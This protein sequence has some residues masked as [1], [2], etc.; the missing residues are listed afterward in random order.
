MADL[1]SAILRGTREAA[2]LHRDLGMR[3]HIAEHGGRIDVFGT[4]VTYGVP[5]LF[6]P[7]DGLLGVF[8]PEP[9][10][11]VLITTQRSLSIQRLTGAHEMGHYRLQHRPSLDDETI[12]RRSPFFSTS[13]YTYCISSFDPCCMT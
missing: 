5:L 13:R 2:R 8:L 10:P 6:K 12:L 3:E 11:G 7:L 9:S 4:L 1:H